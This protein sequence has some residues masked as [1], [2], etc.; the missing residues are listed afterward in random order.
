MIDAS[1]ANQIK[2][3]L[4]NGELTIYSSDQQGK[5]KQGDIYLTV[6]NI[7]SIKSF[8]IVDIEAV[9]NFDLSSITLNLSAKTNIWLYVESN[10]FYCEI[11]GD[12]Y[13]EIEGAVKEF[14]LDMKDMAT[15]D[16]ELKA[17]ELTCN[18]ENFAK[19]YITGLSNIK[20]SIVNDKTRN[21]E[22]INAARES[23]YR[24]SE[25]CF[26]IQRK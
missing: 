7:T 1:E 15:L 23:I 22:Q 5:K 26:Y 25:V 3:E 13:A 24:N 11:N 9:N 20:H 2:T 8:G 12:G 4:K 14:T 19:L 16:L 21:L 18:L 10:Q 6:K 17:N